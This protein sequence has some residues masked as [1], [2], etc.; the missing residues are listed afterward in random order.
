MAPG[1]L[2]GMEGVGVRE[3]VRREWRVRGIVEGVDVVERDEGEWERA[4]RLQSELGNGD[5]MPK[6]V[7]FYRLSGLFGRV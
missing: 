7:V 1:M 4:E 5:L 2:S 3:A 6:D